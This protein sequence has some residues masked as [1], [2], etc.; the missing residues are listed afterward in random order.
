M[1]LS[2]KPLA[3]LLPWR[4]KAPHAD[5]LYGAIVARARLP[6]FY[7]AFG[8]PD[9]LEGR[10]VVLSLHLFAVLH[11]LKDSGPQ[12]AATAQALADHF[13]A[14]METVL[15]ELG[16]GDL[17]IPKKVRKLTASGAG[18]LKSYEMGLAK[19]EGAFEAAIASAL[20]GEEAAAKAA[21]ARL[22]P[23]VREMVQDL[24]SEPLQD[25][26]AGTLRLPDI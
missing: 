16:I 19:G 10:F 11:R 26:C 24:E 17:S 8:V 5:E 13:T 20:P 1:A 22:T 3:S 15:R 21:A 14:D 9:T 12:A 2:L 23:Y 18:L 4:S 25:L 7:Q 6:V